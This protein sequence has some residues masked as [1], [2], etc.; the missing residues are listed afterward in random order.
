MRGHHRPDSASSRRLCKASECR[1]GYYC[2]ANSTS[3]TQFECGH[4]GVFCPA[5]S[6]APTPVS[7]GH[8][9]TPV[10]GWSAEGVQVGSGFTRTGERE[11]KAGHYCGTDGVMRQ[12][13]AGRYGA[14]A[15]LANEA[16]SGLCAK[17]HYCEIGSTS[18]KQRPCPGGTFGDSEGL[19]MPRC[20]GLCA[21]GYY[22]PTGSTSNTCVRLF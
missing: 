4:T 20:S 13:P 9:T 3:P 8:Y 11:C 19:A 12:C 16:C 15:G 18:P 22:C 21:P 2:P 5:G 17:G 14:T 1:E 7:V 6:G 10:D